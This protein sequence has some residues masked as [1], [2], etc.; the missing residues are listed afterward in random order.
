MR[1][2]HRYR[3]CF[4]MGTAIFYLAL[5]VGV[6]LFICPIIMMIMGSLKPD[7]R[8][9]TEAG[10]LKAFI[11]DIVSLQNYRDVFRRTAF[12]RYLLN[13]V[14][15]TG[16]IVAAGLLINSLAAYALARLRWKGRDVVFLM[17]ITVLIVPFESIAV[18]LFYQI[19]IMGLRN[20]YW[21]QIIPFIADAFTIFLFY[22]FFIDL[23]HE[24]EEAAEIDGAT[25][26][27]TFLTI[28][29]PNA[30]PVVATAAILTFLSRWGSYLWPMMVTIGPE[31]RP[32]PVAITTF[33]T[34]PP[35]QWG[36]IM[37]FGV[38]MVSPVLIVFLMFQ[39]WFIR[40]VAA[41][42]IKG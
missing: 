34:L 35:L 1:I 6:L 38:M 33:Y 12:F 32:L 14:F 3:F 29:L 30:K 27:R 17:V 39:R 24:L 21:A 19:S 31:T 15:I 40:S 7:E 8:I 9:L 23:P 13:S 11:P 41:S 37:A 10:S 26:I 4:W 36:D 42:A 18:P 5:V 20:T 22:S 16:A 2:E 25:V 28:V